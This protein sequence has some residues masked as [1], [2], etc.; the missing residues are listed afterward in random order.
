M[1]NQKLLAGVVLFVAAL[2]G[3]APEGLLALPFIAGTT[4]DGDGG[5]EGGDGGGGDPGPGSEGGAPAPDATPAGERPQPFRDKIEKMRAELAAE[6]AGGD[7]AADDDDPEKPKK[8][9]G[10]DGDEGAG[11]EGD[12]EGDGD[13]AG[14]PAGEG[15]EGDGGGEGDDDFVVVSLPGR[16]PTDED[17]ELP[18]DVAALEAAGIDPA[19]AVERLNQLRNGA[20]RRQEHETAM[21]EVATQ[22]DELDGIYQALE[23]NPTAFLIEHVDPK[24][25]AD[26]VRD[27]VLELDDEAFDAFMQRVDGW[28]RDPQTRTVA[29]TDAENK[30]LKAERERSTDVAADNAQKKLVRDIS[31]AIRSVLPEDFDQRRARMFEREAAAELREHAKK[32]KL[33]HLDPAEIPELLAELGVLEVFNISANG[34]EPEPEGSAAERPARKAAGKNGADGKK[35]SKPAPAPKKAPDVRERLKRR[36]SAATT[37]AGAGSAAP[38]GFTKVPG[39]TYEQRRNRLARALGVKEKKLS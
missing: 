2:L 16:R 30:R 3:H 4:G 36:K 1:L 14:A 38:A 11:G 32:N 22:Q 33:T 17:F 8:P 18:L 20:M 10:E 37:P 19:D 25:R 12:G 9:E 28:A 31:T 23:Q 15:G 26:V 34:H 39:E 35:P 27:L 5:G 13:A 24:M 21:A 29:R 6:G 7:A